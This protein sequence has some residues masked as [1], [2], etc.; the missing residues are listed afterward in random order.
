MWNYS[1]TPSRGI[2]EF[3]L[4]I[5]DTLVYRGY[6]RKAPP[7]PPKKPDGTL[8]NI[9]FG[10][11]VLFTDNHSILEQEVRNVYQFRQEDSLLLIDNNN[12][13]SS[14][15]DSM[16]GQRPTTTMSR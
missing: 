3:D 2:K 6:V 14:K 12:V 7:R 16:W 9:A 4:Y 8:P 13:I 5:D 11:A 10:Q 1:K 15:D